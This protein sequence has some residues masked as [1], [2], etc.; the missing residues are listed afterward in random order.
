MRQ[1]PGAT[2]A[3]AVTGLAATGPRSFVVTMNAPNACATRL[4]RV[5]MG[6]AGLPGALAPIGP[7]LP[8]ML[9][10]LAAGAGGRVIGYAVSGCSKGAP[11]YPGVLQLSSGRARQWGNVSLGG[12]SSGSLVLQGQLSISAN[13]R[14]L[15]FATD[16]M[17]R[18]G[19][20]TGQS[21]RVLATD[22]PPGAVA[23]RSRVVYR[24][25]APGAAGRLDLAAASISPSGTSVYVCRQAGT[26][27]MATAQVVVNLAT[28]ATSTVAFRMPGPVGMFEET[29]TSI[30]AW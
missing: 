27:T 25:G 12:L 30:V 1:Y 18:D 13:G 9:W 23:R 10:S 16:A 21:V 19:V 17:S 26:R 20:F 29:G 8:G 11:G 5:R 7:T 24:Q 6:A 3:D 2:T 4:Y 14:L 28:R 22:A 15:V